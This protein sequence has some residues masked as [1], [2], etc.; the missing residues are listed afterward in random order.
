MPLSPDN[1][2][3][4]GCPGGGLWGRGSDP[5]CIQY[6]SAGEDLSAANPAVLYGESL[7]SGED[8]GDHIDPAVSSRTEFVSYGD[9]DK[10][11]SQG[12]PDAQRGL[13]TSPSASQARF[14]Y[15]SSKVT[16]NNHAYADVGQHLVGND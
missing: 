10:C 16:S 7:K 12:D 1:P 11:G 15:S 3:G 6:E 13:V 2:V 14:A 5:L 8:D 9:V 4:S